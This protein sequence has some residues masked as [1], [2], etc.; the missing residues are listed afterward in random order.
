MEK[1]NEKENPNKLIQD[2]LRKLNDLRELNVNP[3]PY[4]YQPTHKAKDINE[5]YAGLK[6]EEETKDN[7]KVAGRIMQLRN[8]GK[9]CFIHL[10]DSTGK[11]QL[12]LRKED[13]GDNY[14]LLKKLDLGD[15]IGAEGHIFKTKMGE[16]T[17]YTKNFEVLCKS[18]RP[19]PEKYH[20]LQ[21]VEIR[22]RKR[23]LDL[24]TNPN[25][26]D[27]FVTRSKIIKGIRNYLDDRGYVEVQV[28]M[29]QP[30]YG[31][32]AA[33]P[34]KTHH[35]D[36]D[37][38]LYLKISPELYLKRLI[39]GG[40]DKVYDIS[41]NFRNEGTD[42]NHNPE[43]TM[44]EWYEA[45]ADYN[46]MMRMTEELVSG[47]VKELHGSTK[48]TYQGTELDF[49]MPW[50]RLKMKDAIKEYADIDIDD[51]DDEQIKEL[52]DTY[53]LE[54]H[55]DV[56]RG[57]IVQVLFEELAEDK[58]IQPT[59]IIDHPVEVSPLTKIHR[60]DKGFVERFELF[61][62]KME[63]ANAY[64]ELNDPIDQKNRLEEQEASRAVDD[65][66]HPMDEDF[67]EAI[68]TGMPPTGG[69]G[70]GVDRLVMILTD[71]PSI[72]DVILFPTMKPQD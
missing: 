60:T 46:D 56:T 72:R 55:G 26:R 41:Y 1:T 69:I 53:N 59:F 22:Y 57:G 44:I 18:L 40:F 63:L 21:D 8:M 29:L 12:Y 16:V 27:T 52:I 17:V 25:I 11:V 15:F 67:V 23:Y 64:S 36:L 13:L 10:M 37:M 70:I 20:G 51:Y 32:A 2:R 48:L 38:P 49:T 24:I 14:K 6:A 35:N 34:F 33:R 42:T 54:Y 39:V 3:Y 62:N 61:I 31:G 45:Y 68:E 30:I 58:L 4:S 66:A 65:E 28:P 7:V 43:F 9:I 50:R 47:L 19:L 5:K 71:S